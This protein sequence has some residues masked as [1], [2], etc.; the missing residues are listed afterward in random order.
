LAAEVLGLGV[1]MGGGKAIF[2]VTEVGEEHKPGS[3]SASPQVHCISAIF[4]MS[5]S[6]GNQRI[7]V[8]VRALLADPTLQKLH[9]VFKTVGNVVVVLEF[10]KWYCETCYLKMG[11]ELGEYVIAADV[12]RNNSKHTPYQLTLE[13]VSEC[14]RALVNA[15]TTMKRRNDEEGDGDWVGGGKEQGVCYGF[16][17]GSCRFGNACRFKHVPR[18][19]NGGGEDGGGGGDGGGMMG[20]RGWSNTNVCFDF[21]KN[22]CNRGSGCRFLH[23][24]DAAGPMPAAAAGAGAAK[25][26]AGGGGRGGGILTWGGGTDTLE[27]RGRAGGR[28]GGRGGRGG[29][30]GERECYDFKVGRCLKGLH[31]KWLHPA[32]AAA[33]P[34]QETAEATTKPVEATTELGEG[35]KT[36]EA[37]GGVEGGGDA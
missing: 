8:V 29:Q 2:D 15:V 18:L 3:V 6:G 10:D 13:N 4:P 19:G 9:K 16:Q 1:G 22:M 11:E 30:A 24:P 34:A 27:S 23:T 21:Q 25:P 33:A 31:C 17:K 20:G 35:A 14:N 7:G 28:D 32:A 12:R 36:A 37:L 26:P 5:S